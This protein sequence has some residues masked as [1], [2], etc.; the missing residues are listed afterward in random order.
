MSQIE[1]AV[2]ATTHVDLSIS[3]LELAIRLGYAMRTMLDFRKAGK[4]PPHF[5]SPTG[6]A[7]RQ[8]RYLISDVEQYE[9]SLKSKA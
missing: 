1:S 6:R 3:E 7:P 8:V 9:Q 4:L 2:P 5:L